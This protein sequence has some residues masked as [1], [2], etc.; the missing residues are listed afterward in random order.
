M[1]KLKKIIGFLTACIILFPCLVGAQSISLAMPGTLGG[2]LQEAIVSGASDPNVVFDPNAAVDTQKTL[3]FVEPT[4][5][6]GEYGFVF[7]N[8]SDVTDLTVKIMTIETSLGGGT[9]YG[10]ITSVSIPKSQSISGTTINTYTKYVTGVFNGAAC[11][12]IF[13]N[14][15][16]TGE[17]G[18]FTSTARVRAV[19]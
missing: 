8:P 19:K 11:Q 9:R 14:D 6:Y 4:T 2:V 17:G 10:Y 18:G 15:T 13:S 5:S 7:Y 3:T 12:L 16:D 1:I